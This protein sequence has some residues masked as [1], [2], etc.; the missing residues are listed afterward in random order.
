MQSLKPL[1]QEVWQ[2]IFQHLSKSDLKTIRLISSTWSDLALRFLFDTAYISSFKIDYDV[3]A[4]ISNHPVLSKCVRYLYFDASQFPQY[5]SKRQY[6]NRLV[7]QISH[8]YRNQ[9]HSYTS[10]DREVNELLAVLDGCDCDR[11]NKDERIAR[12]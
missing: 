2:D 6:L 12:I 10:K 4:Q 5:V 1:P 7:Q 9:E 3:L 8:F 11:I